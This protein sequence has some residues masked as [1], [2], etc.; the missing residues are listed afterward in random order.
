MSTWRFVAQDLG[1]SRKKEWQ[2]SE[3]R[4][5]SVIGAVDWTP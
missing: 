4:R 2:H 5:H 3:L 1:N